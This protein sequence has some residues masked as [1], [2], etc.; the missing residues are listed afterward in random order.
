MFSVW[1]D[2]SVAGFTG[3]V[4]AHLPRPHSLQCV[5]AWFAAAIGL[6]SV[7]AIFENQYFTMQQHLRN[8]VG[9]VTR[10]TANFPLSVPVTE[11]LKIGQ[12]CQDMSKKLVS[13]FHDRGVIR[14]PAR[15]LEAHN[16]YYTLRCTSIYT[17]QCR[18]GSLRYRFNPFD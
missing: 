10:F 17:F 14:L 4:Q 8:V 16:R 5:C 18:N 11:F 15:E 1:Y 2:E 3:L 9:S 7:G 12:Y 6:L 13:C